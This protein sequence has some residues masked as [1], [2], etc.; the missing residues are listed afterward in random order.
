MAK[1]RKRKK[2]GFWAGLSPRGR[3]YFVLMICF[4]LVLLTSIAA[5]AA[6]H[7]MAEGQTEPA[8]SEPLVENPDYNKDENTI[9]AS[10]YTSTILMESEDAGQSYIDETLF[11]G[12]SNTARMRMFGFCTLDNSAASVGMAASALA[13]YA[14]VKFDGYSGYKTMPEAVA[15]MQPRRVIITF[16][17]NDLTPSL[18]TE[19][20]IS[21]YQ[22][23]IEAVQQAYPSVDIIINAIPPIGRQ[24]AGEHL[25]QTQIDQFNKAIVQMCVAHDWKFLNSAEVLRDPETGYAKDGYVIQ[26]DGIHLTEEAIGVLFDYIRTHSYITEDDRPALTDIPEHLS[27]K[28]VSA[29]TAAT[30]ITSQPSAPTAAPSSEAPEPTQE[31][32]PEPAPEE[33]EY[34]YRSEVIQPTCTEQGYTIYHCNEDPGLDYTDNYVEALGHT[35]PNAEG[36]CDRCGTQLE[37]PTEPTDDSSTTGDSSTADNSV[38]DSSVTESTDSAPESTGTESEQ[39]EQTGPDSS[40][41]QQSE[42]AEPAENTETP[43][44]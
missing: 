41:E 1:R 2:T 9:D 15:L 5:L 39:P 19:R 29:T 32:T 28:D 34:T 16:G 43:T 13:D 11:L 42:P 38:A 4:A 18:T 36:K 26:S 33:I 3:M 14:C 7:G 40:A 6:V 8:A 35:E 12:D 30:V 20:F 24:H 21:E 23:G 44:E 31:P 22:A 25:T 10:Q 37:Q 17:T 27:D